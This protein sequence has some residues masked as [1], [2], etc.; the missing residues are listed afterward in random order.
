M[1]SKKPEA[2]RVFHARNLIETSDVKAKRK[3]LIHENITELTVR[4][5]DVFRP[6]TLGG[7]L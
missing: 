7:M 6:V 3:G 1:P 4:I 2:I 5:P